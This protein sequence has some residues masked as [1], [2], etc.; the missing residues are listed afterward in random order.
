MYPDEFRFILGRTNLTCERCGNCCHSTAGRCVYL[1]EGKLATCQIHEKKPTHC[2]EFPK[3]WDYQWMV[4]WNLGKPER[5][6]EFCGIV[7]KFWK[8]AYIFYKEMERV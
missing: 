8:E 4:S 7:R 3:V 2:L 6:T 1:L 5:A